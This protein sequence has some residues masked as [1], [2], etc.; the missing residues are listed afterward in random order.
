VI[1]WSPVDDGHW[2][3]WPVTCVEASVTAEWQ[4]GADGSDGSCCTSPRPTLFRLPVFLALPFF[5]HANTR[6]QPVRN[7]RKRKRNSKNSSGRGNATDTLAWRRLLGITAARPAAGQLSKPGPSAGSHGGPDADNTSG[8]EIHCSG[9]GNRL[10][11]AGSARGPAKNHVTLRTASFSRS[12]G[13]IRPRDHRQLGCLWPVKCRVSVTPGA[14][15]RA[16][17]AAGRQDGRAVARRFRPRAGS[18]TSCALPL[19]PTPLAGW[20]PGWGCEERTGKPFVFRLLWGFCSF[21][22]TLTA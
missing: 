21:Q 7:V 12:P 15:Y 4:G 20:A 5:P 16:N 8:A 9:A 13:L 19:P 22:G 1:S 3:R 6:N 2:C 11:R 14:R 17:S 10:G 18:P